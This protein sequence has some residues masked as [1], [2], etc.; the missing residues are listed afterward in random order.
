MTDLRR[1]EGNRSAGGSAIT[2]GGRA[3]RL[4][5]DIDVEAITKEVTEDL[6]MPELARSVLR[7]FEYDERFGE[8]VAQCSGISEVEERLEELEVAV[9]NELYITEEGLVESLVKALTSL[10]DSNKERAEA[11]RELRK[12]IRVLKGEG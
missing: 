9:V 6:D 4:E 3:M 8:M 5:I 10:R 2:Q 11:N 12:E 7:E 1:G